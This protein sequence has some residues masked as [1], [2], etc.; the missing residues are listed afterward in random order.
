MYKTVPTAHENDDIE[1]TKGQGLGSTRWNGCLCKF[2]E[3][4]DNEFI[5]S[6][7]LVILCF[8]KFCIKERKFIKNLFKID[9]F[10]KNKIK[11]KPIKKII[12]KNDNLILF[13]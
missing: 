2:L 5:F 6:Y 12:W 11:N 3:T 8:I 13:R 4:I 10:E 1:A 7:F 9:E